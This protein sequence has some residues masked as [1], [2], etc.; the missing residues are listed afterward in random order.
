MT[1]R[2]RP[3]EPVERALGLPGAG[4]GG[5]RIEE[6]LPVLEIE[7][8]KALAPVAIAG[9]EIDLHRP[10]AA[11]RR[12]GPARAAAPRARAASARPPSSSRGSAPG[13]S[14]AAHA[15]LS[16]EPN[17]LCGT[18]KTTR[19]TT[20]GDDDRD[21]RRAASG[22]SAAGAARERDERDTP[23]DHRDRRL[24]V[25]QVVAEGPAGPPGA[26][27][28]LLHR[29]TEQETADGE[30]QRTP[31]RPVAAPGRAA[32]APRA[33]RR[34]RTACRRTSPRCA[35]PGRAPAPRP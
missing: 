19:V 11:P 3:G 10:R 32:R 5:R 16:S 9:R 1:G 25:G 18:T 35:A 17:R 15:T 7:H 33:P 30:Q 13:R 26:E 27:G 24:V 20:R 34:S 12:R 14:S 8:R 6:V 28:V 31:P 22:A 29:R 21:A 4:E 2:P 23:G